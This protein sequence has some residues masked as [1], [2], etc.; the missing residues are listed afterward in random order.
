MAEIDFQELFAIPTTAFPF[1][2][3]LYLWPVLCQY[4]VLSFAPLG[5]I[6]F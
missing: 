4:Y 5:A 2:S 1:I 3:L 6:F